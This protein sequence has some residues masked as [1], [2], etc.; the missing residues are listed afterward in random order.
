[1][2]KPQIKYMQ[3][4]NQLLID[5]FKHRFLTISQ[6][7]R[8]HFPSL[9]TA[10]RRLRLLRQEGLL[11]TFNVP[12]IDESIFNLTA[13]GHGAVSVSLGIDIDEMNITSL[14]TK[15]H[16][17]YFMRHFL[18]INDFR[19]MLRQ[20]CVNNNIRLLGFIPDY[21]GERSTGFGIKKYIKDIT[22]DITHR[23]EE[24]SHTPDGVFSL[25]C[26][27]KAALFFLEID[28]G[29]EVVA[30]PIKGVLKAFRFYAGYLLDGNYQKYSRDFGIKPF[31]GFRV[32]LVTNSRERI[33]NIRRAV[34]SAEFPDKIKRFFWLSTYDQLKKN[35]L[36]ETFWLSSLESDE[37]L[38]SLLG[39]D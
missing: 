7:R 36:F 18:A 21:Y 8:L 33:A 25:E 20:S 2:K 37:S 6:I 39:R 28:K 16:D 34:T 13:K 5:I 31:K 17:Y 1:M 38:H 14:R 22:C 15:P 26:N 35:G 3:R 4:D 29:T 23:E 24:L 10:Y 30:N 11:K 32:L 19:I 9:Q 27:G 12:G